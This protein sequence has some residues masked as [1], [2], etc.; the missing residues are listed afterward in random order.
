MSQTSE[1]ENLLRGILE[2]IFFVPIFIT[3]SVGPLL[4]YLKNFDS[5]A[6]F[7]IDFS[8][9][10]F[11]VG[12]FSLIVKDNR[13]GFSNFDKV[14]S[15][16][17]LSGSLGMTLLFVTPYINGPE[18]DVAYLPPILHSFVDQVGTALILLV[19]VISLVGFSVSFGKA[20]HDVIKPTWKEFIYGEER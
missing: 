19:F 8:M 1:L 13:E 5:P 14:G 6:S 17:L 11:T 18:A 16:Y 7:L 12:M 10:A 20:T 9:I 3:L 4:Y 2:K 15:W